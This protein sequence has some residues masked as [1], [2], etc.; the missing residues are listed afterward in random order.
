[1]YFDAH[2]MHTTNLGVIFCER[3]VDGQKQAGK[4]NSN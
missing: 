4:N 3:K 1:M 2:C